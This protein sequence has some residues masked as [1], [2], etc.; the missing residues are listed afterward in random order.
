MVLRSASSLLRN[1]PSILI[2]FVFCFVLF[3]GI[4]I[5]NVVQTEIPPPKNVKELF[6]SCSKDFDLKETSDGGLGRLPQNLNSVSGL[7]LFNS[8]ENP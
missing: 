8:V 1:S 3:L 6:S 5:E 2:R 7:M 4:L